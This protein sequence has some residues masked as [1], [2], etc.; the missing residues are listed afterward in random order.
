MVTMASTT[1]KND[2]G[3]VTALARVAT[4]AMAFVSLPAAG[5]SPGLQD[6]EQ[7]QGLQLEADFRV[8]A[9]WTDNIFLLDEPNAVEET[10]Y[11]VSP[12]LSIDYTSARVEFNGRYQYDFYDYRELDTD[13]QQHQYDIMMSNEIFEDTFY[14]DLG[15]SRTQ[16]VVDPDAIVPPGNLP[17]SNNLVD[18]DDYYLMPRID[19][20][21][22]GGV[23]ARA[24]Y[25]YEDV[26][27]DDT[28]AD[29]VLDTVNKNTLVQI[30][31]IQRQQGLTFLLSYEHEESDYDDPVI[32]PWEFE[33]ATGQLGYWASDSFR[34]FASGGEESAWDDP[35]DRSMQDGFWEAGFE[36]LGSDR[37]RAE[38]AAGERSFGDSWRGDLE[39]K[40]RRGEL[41][42]SYEQ[43]PTTI[44]QDQFNNGLLDPNNPGDV[45]ARPGSAERY[46]SNRGEASMDLEFRRSTLNLLLYDEDRTGRFLADGTELPDESQ[47]GVLLSFNFQAGPRTE[48]VGEGS[49]Y[50][51]ATET[52]GETD[53]TF[54]RITANYQLIS[55]FSISLAYEYGEQLSSDDSNTPEYESNLVSLF[56]IYSFRN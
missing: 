20:T 34:I 56:L 24:E 31:N 23:R 11:Q 30:D 44:G 45:L 8:G 13:S 16:S 25:R 5:Q 54:A 15:G 27:F 17:I 7:E 6:G 21:F 14:F 32:L 41:I 9:N 12:F 52:N 2:L 3:V 42:F 40:F 10:V 43:T 39:F 47:R 1:H 55:R 37:V 22:A 18:R 35:V 38:F 53:F 51:R 36:L 4:V 48:I 46:I 50:S 49:L 26:Q 19:R 29:D 33:K 28:D